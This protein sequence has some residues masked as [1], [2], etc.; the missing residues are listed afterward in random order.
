M[1]MPFAM[2]NARTV[3]FM[4][5]CLLTGACGAKQG[6]PTLP[7]PEYEPARVLPAAAS[8]AAVVGM[9]PPLS[10]ALPVRPAPP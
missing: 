3:V 4:V 8:S 1:D 9:E 5:A 6:R 7:P 2:M 10:S